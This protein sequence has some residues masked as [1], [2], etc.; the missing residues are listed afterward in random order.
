FSGI[1]QEG[2]ALGSILASAAFGLLFAGFR[3]HGLTIPGIGWRGLFVLGAT[4]AL[5][6]F[7]VLAR[8]PESPVWLAGAAKRNAGKAAQAGPGGSERWRDFL[9]T[10]LFLVVL[11]T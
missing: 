8:V 4:P 5:L 3:W 11:M 2:Y 7:Y 10:F 6:V 1:L 9:P